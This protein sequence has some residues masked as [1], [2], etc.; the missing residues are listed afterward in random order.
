MPTLVLP[1]DTEFND[2]Q[3]ARGT[4]VRAND[5]AIRDFINNA[6]IDNTNINLAANYPWTGQHSW[7]GVDRI[8]LPTNTPTVSRSLALVSGILQAHDGTSARTYLRNEP[9]ASQ[10]FAAMGYN[11]GNIND[12]VYSTVES[13]TF[14]VTLPGVYY[15]YCRSVYAVNMGPA[16][17]VATS[18]SF[19]FRLNPATFI[20]T[21]TIKLSHTNSGGITATT[22][23]YTPFTLN[24]VVVLTAGMQTVEL[25]KT[26]NTSTNITSR[27]LN[28]DN[29]GISFGYFR[30][31]D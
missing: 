20:A 23:I 18:T 24:G 6:Q 7:T 31:S 27:L 3:L 5:Q 4:D 17:S 29:S 19:T 16:A 9:A 11:L 2:G 15:L 12:A 14:N 28:N 30:V 25:R 26:N 10:L 13:W 1:K 8:L 22:D 21:T